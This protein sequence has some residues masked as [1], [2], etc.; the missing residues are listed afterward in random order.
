LSLFCNQCKKKMQENDDY[1]KHYSFNYFLGL[2]NWS[3]FRL[4]VT[5]P[6]NIRIARSKSTKLY[7]HNSIK[8]SV[9]GIWKQKRF[10][11]L[12]NWI[13]HTW[14]IIHSALQIQYFSSANHFGATLLA[15]VKSGPIPTEFKKGNIFKN[16]K[17][18]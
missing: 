15:L 11:G 16:S 3:S 17:L 18:E 2:T 6:Y 9:V 7:V 14:W 4:T 8:S 12:K 10:K 1:G 13:L 5:T